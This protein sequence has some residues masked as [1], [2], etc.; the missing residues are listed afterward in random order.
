MAARYSIKFADIDNIVDG[1]DWAII[2]DSIYGFWEYDFMHFTA[3]GHERL[4]KAL[5][6]LI[7]ER[8]N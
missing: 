3:R 5:Y 4:S 8:V 1:P 2:I 6:P 7:T